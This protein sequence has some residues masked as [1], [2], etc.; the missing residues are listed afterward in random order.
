VPIVMTAPLVPVVFKMVD[1]VPAPR[2]TV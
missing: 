2:K 1:R